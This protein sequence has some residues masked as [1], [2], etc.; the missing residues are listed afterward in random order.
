MKILKKPDNIV[1]DTATP[2]VRICQAKSYEIVCPLHHVNN[3]T[4][5]IFLKEHFPSLTKGT[6]HPIMEN[7]HQSYYFKIKDHVQIQHTP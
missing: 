6:D 4:D 3:V 5:Y 7:F 1:F 2:H